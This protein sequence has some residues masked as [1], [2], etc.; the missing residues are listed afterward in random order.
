VKRGE[1]GPKR[2]ECGPPAIPYVSV[3]VYTGGGASHLVFA[4]V[5]NGAR[6]QGNLAADDGHVD[7]GYIERRLQS[8]AAANCIH[9]SNRNIVL[10]VLVDISWL[11]ASCCA[12]N[13]PLS[14]AFDTFYVTRKTGPDY[15]LIAVIA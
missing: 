5:V 7:N 12:C 14:L 13:C 9:N 8:A 3:P 10:Q 1:C 2:G 6:Q 11:S 15:F 4:E